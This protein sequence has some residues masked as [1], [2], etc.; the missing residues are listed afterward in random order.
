MLQLAGVRQ[1]TK[2]GRWRHRRRFG[3][4]GWTEV[5]VGTA[6]AQTALADDEKCFGRGSR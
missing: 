2:A 4:G 5:H 6:G 1:H 3:I